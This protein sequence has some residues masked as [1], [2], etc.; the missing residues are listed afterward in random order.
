MYGQLTAG[1]GGYAPVT[2]ASPAMAS[3]RS[4]PSGFVASGHTFRVHK[5]LLAPG[6]SNP[7]MRPADMHP[8]S[9]TIDS[10]AGSRSRLPRGM[11]TWDAANF[12][13]P[14]VFAVQFTLHETWA[15]SAA[16]TRAV[17]QRWEAWMAARLQGAPP[18]LQQGFQ[19]SDVRSSICVCQVLLSTA[20][21]TFT[22]ATTMSHMKC[23]RAP[24]VSI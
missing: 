21:L 23:S 11:A 17:W 18:G 22:A 3:S 5:D 16:H 1:V 12:T 19:S 10:S 15:T 20:S 2:F 7:R 14:A 4:N 9:W 8:R 13:V 24:R 6:D